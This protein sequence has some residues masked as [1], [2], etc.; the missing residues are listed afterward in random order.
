VGGSDNDDDDDDD[1]DEDCS[2]A[3][4]RT[5]NVVTKKTQVSLPEQALVPEQM[6]VQR[7]YHQQKAQAAPTALA[8]VQSMK[9]L[10]ALQRR[11]LAA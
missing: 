10:Q 9:R 11:W 3:Y 8:V 6:K 2:S 5:Q 4:S 7:Y 1:D